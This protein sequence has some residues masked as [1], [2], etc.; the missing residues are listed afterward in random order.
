MQLHD[1]IKDSAVLIPVESSFLLH[2]DG[3]EAGSLKQPVILKTA[4]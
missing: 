1:W 4:T 3:Y 2:A